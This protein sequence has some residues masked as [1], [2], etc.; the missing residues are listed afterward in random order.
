MKCLV[1]Y[2][3][4]S[5]N[6][7]QVA[8]AIHAAL[9]P[10]CVLAEAAERGGATREGIFNALSEGKPFTSVQFGEFTFGVD[11]RPNDVPIVPVI[12]R[13]GTYEKL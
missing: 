5:G 1:V 3:S 2:S 10:E 13:D 11:R 7:G 12:V 8:R 4:R 6:T 9:G